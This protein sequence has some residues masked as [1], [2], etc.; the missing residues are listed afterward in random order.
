MADL[1]DD[2]TFNLKHRLVGAIVLIVVAVI[3]LPRVLTGTDAAGRGK[4][5][6]TR[7]APSVEILTG[8]SIGALKLEGFKVG[9][10]THIEILEAPV[11]ADN[12]DEFGRQEANRK[13][14]LED[15]IDEKSTESVSELNSL[16]SSVSEAVV[17]GWIAQV[18]VFKD[19][20]NAEKVMQNLEMNSIYGKSELIIVKESRVTRIWVGPFSTRDEAVREGNKAMMVT[21]SPA[22]IKEWP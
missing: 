3:L 22:I 1:L 12:S 18:G 19:L 14:Q 17:T 15:S 21:E 8:P 10:E 9:I 13:L 11:T 2:G 7:G 20:Q 6:E 4:S 5:H 16:I